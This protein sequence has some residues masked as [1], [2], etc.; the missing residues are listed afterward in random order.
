[1]TAAA[2]YMPEGQAEFDVWLK[3]FSTL[4]QSEPNRYNL[5]QA[6][7]AII[8]DVYAEWS[9]A[10]RPVTAPI[11]KT[12]VA[13]AAKN[14]ARKMAE[15]TI[16]PCCKSSPTTATYRPADKLAL[17]PQS[18]DATAARQIKPPLAGPMLSVAPAGSLLLKLTYQYCG[19]GVSRR[20]KPPGVTACQLYYAVSATR[21]TDIDQLPSERAGHE[22]AACRFS[23]TPARRTCRAYF[24]ARWGV[25]TGGVSPWS[26]IVS[27][28]IP[29]GGEAA[30][31][32]E[33][34]SHGR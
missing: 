6:D 23:S 25:Q 10:Y 33:S 22:V 21:I 30:L 31:V 27:F 20:A 32:H 14:A 17:R 29:M 8:R 12:K 5:S 19:S 26:R 15:A 2:P 1:M 7:A 28:S 34:Y 9:A 3:N 16:R 4:V 13:V 24:A 18:A 11:T